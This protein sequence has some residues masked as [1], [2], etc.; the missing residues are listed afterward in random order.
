MA[1][2]QMV[3]SK[4]PTTGAKMRL[5]R[6]MKMMRKV[7]RVTTQSSAK[8]TSKGK[9]KECGIGASLLAKTATLWRPGSRYIGQGRKRCKSGCPARR[10]QLLFALEIEMHGPVGGNVLKKNGLVRL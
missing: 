5:P 9:A 6:E 2:S 3:T 10:F 1:N 8:K 7:A 4:N